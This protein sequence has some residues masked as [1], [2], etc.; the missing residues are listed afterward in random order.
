MK[1]RKSK[2]LLFPGKRFC[3][4]SFYHKKLKY[5]SRIMPLLA[6]I[7][8]K[9]IKTACFIAF[10]D[11]ENFQ[12]LLSAVFAEL[13][14][15]IRQRPAKYRKIRERGKSF[16]P[17][18]NKLEIQL[19]NISCSKKFL[20]RKQSPFFS[21][22]LQIFNGNKSQVPLFGKFHQIGFGHH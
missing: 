20:P 21:V 5:I 2:T 6:A 18:K 12:S 10:I 13:K 9:S 3:Q 15:K 14:P 1:P 4:S 17:E 16:P 19:R 7:K 8:K 11:R 22:F